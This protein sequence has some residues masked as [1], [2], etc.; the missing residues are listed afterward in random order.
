MLLQHTGQSPKKEHQ[1]E[2]VADQIQCTL[3][4]LVY[5]SGKG[6][7]VG[8]FNVEKSQRF[9]ATG[10]MAAPQK[11]YSYELSGAWIINPKY[12]RQF[13][14]D[15]YKSIKPTDLDGLFRYIVHTAKWVGPVVGKRLIDA[16]NFDVLDVLKDDPEGVA[17]DIKGITKAR[18]G[19]I[20]RKMLASEKT[21]SLIVELES[22]VGGL[23]LRKSLPYEIAERWKS[24]AGAIIRKN[25]YV[26]CELRNVGFLTADKIAVSRVK[27]PLDA[28]ERK[29]AAIEYVLQQNESNGNV[30]IVAVELRDITNDLISCDASEQ[31]IAQIKNQVIAYEEGFVATNIAAQ[32]EK[33]VA[34]KLLEMSGDQNG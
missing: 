6:Y 26:L 29:N 12:G 1:L 14:F 21:E 7:I 10:N 25:P 31:I 17:R 19:D 27:I 24:D 3:H 15:S 11:G 16:Y 33:F 30:W 18:A 4:H 20:Q 9:T 8:S 34:R 2:A 22:L 23:G 5:E 13:K 32:N 28:I